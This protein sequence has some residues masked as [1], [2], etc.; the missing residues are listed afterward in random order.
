MI[1]QH[2]KLA[3]KL[4][5]ISAFFFCQST[6]ALT[7]KIEQ[8][9]DVVG[10]IQYF[11]TKKGDDL[12]TVARKFD[13]GLL[14]LQ[15]A[16]PKINP[17]KVK[18]GTKLVIPTAFILPPGERTGIVI[19]LAEI[20]VYHFSSD[21]KTVSTYPLGIGKQ[22]W[23]TPIGETTIIRKREHP[24]WTPP[25]N[26][27]EEEE[28]RGIDLPDVIPAGPHNPLGNY[29]MNL[30]WNGYEMHG[31]N[32][33]NSIGLRSS[34]GCMRMYPEDIE[35][36]FK[37]TDVGTKVRVIYEPYKLGVKDG[38][39]FLEAHELFP[40]NYYNIDHGDKYSM[41]Q[42]VVKTINYPATTEVNWE[43]A[44]KLISTANGY[45]VNISDAI[46]DA[47]NNVSNGR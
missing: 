45:P 2:N 41:L 12:H 1:K 17:D 21:G 11:V 36:L 22:G 23:R 28:E 34:H 19:N 42:N 3:L 38:D 10:D 6:Q 7:Y 39:L 13:L 5:I 46:D 30:G 29:A 24:T 33:P 15:E 16:N 14:E 27:R 47:G 31:T 43:A 20:R 37:S 25:D 44:K 9:S 18:P 26:I 8:G 40:D 35:S 32:A 4:I